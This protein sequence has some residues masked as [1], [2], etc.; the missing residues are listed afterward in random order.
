M[1]AVTCWSV[2]LFFFIVLC[3][4]CDGSDWLN[5]FFWKFLVSGSVGGWI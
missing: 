1:F 3:G 5:G 4:V 2:G